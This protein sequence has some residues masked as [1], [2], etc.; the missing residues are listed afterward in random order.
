MFVFGQNLLYFCAKKINNRHAHC[1]SSIGNQ[2]R[3]PSR[4]ASPLRRGRPRPEGGVGDGIACYKNTNYNYPSFRST[5]KDA[6]TRAIRHTIG[7]AWTKNKNRTIYFVYI[8]II[9]LDYH[10]IHKYMYMYRCVFNVLEIR[11]TLQYTNVYR[12]KIAAIH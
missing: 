8:I 2:F 5:L 4:N 12:I 11:V 1:S 7:T 6:A 9:I 3:T 10:E